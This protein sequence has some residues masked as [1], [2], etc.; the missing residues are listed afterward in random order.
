[1][2][3]SQNPTTKQDCRRAT[4]IFL[5]PHHYFFWQVSFLTISALIFLQF[6]QLN[7]GYSNFSYVRSLK[8]PSA[9]FS[10][11]LGTV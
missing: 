1:M 10:R 3:T 5:D 7:L 11:D 8:I 9:H 2:P 4:T 6:L